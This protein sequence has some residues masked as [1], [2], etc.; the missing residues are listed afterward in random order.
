MTSPRR[1]IF[2]EGMGSYSEV[3][4]VRRK[5]SMSLIDVGGVL[6]WV[7]SKALRPVLIDESTE[8]T[9]RAD[10]FEAAREAIENAKRK[11]QRWRIWQLILDEL[12][13]RT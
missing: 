3:V 6:C 5:G 4:E 7:Q 1:A 2:H 11:H 13:G 12:E 8:D 10:L 9:A